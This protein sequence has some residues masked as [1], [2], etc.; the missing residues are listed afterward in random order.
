MFSRGEIFL[1]T[2]R[3]LAMRDF[4]RSVIA[5]RGTCSPERAPGS[6]KVTQLGNNMARQQYS[7]SRHSQARTCPE[8]LA[9]AG[10]GGSS[11]FLYFSCYFPSSDSCSFSLS[12]SCCLGG[13]AQLTEDWPHSS[14][15]RWLGRNKLPGMART[16]SCPVGEVQ[17]GRPLW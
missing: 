6:F 3:Q 1:H 15:S 10:R 13:Q 17:W 11:Y 5:Q 4:Q 12:Q 14:Q 9:W 7:R 16:P 2:Y 8:L